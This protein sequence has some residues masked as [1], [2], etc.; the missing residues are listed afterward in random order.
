ML[1]THPHYDRAECWFSS[2]RKKE[3]FATCIITEGTLLRLHMQLAL[4]GSAEAAWLSLESLRKHA[5]H[6][7][8]EDS[9]S[10]EE[11]NYHNLSGHSQVT[12]A[13]LAELARRRK[14]RGATL[15]VAFSVLYPDIATLVPVTLR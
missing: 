6:V 14:G 4:D 3:R 5:R 12:E 1:D 13:W 8:W 9:F 7:D 2:W 11:I 10:Y 15:D